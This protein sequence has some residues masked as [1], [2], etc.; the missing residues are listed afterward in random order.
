MHQLPPTILHALLSLEK[1]H[2]GKV[3]AEVWN[4][5]EITSLT[6]SQLVNQI[7]R[8]AAGYTRFEI[9]KG[10]RVVIFSPHHPCQYAAYLAAMAVQAIPT[11]LTPLTRKLQPDIYW[12]QQEH[13][14][15]DIKPDLIISDAAGATLLKE[16]LPEI[17]ARLAIFE[18]FENIPSIATLEDLINDIDTDALALIQYSSGT[19][20]PRKAVALSHRSLLAQIES[21]AQ[22]LSLREDDRIA[23][24]LPLYHDMGLITGFIL[25]V[26]KGISFIA[27]D[28]LEWT[29]QPTKLLDAIESFKATLCWLPN[30][31]FSHM[32][33][34]L[35]A[36]RGWSLE[37]IRMM[38]N[39]S[40]PCRGKTFDAFLEKFEKMGIRKD[41]LQASYA[42]AENVF[43]VTQT[44]LSNSD[45]RFGDIVSSGVPIDGVEIKITSED[46]RVLDGEEVGEILIRSSFCLHSYFGQSQSALDS[47]GWY[48]TNDLGAKV[49]NDLFVLGRKDDVIVSRG[50][51]I[52]ASEIESELASIEGIKAGRS[53]CLGAYS[54]LAGSNNLVV[55]VELTAQAN[56]KSI[57][58]QIH[59]IVEAKCGLAPW[60]VYFVEPGWIVKTSSGKI[61]RRTNGTK[62]MSLHNRAST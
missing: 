55:I 3:L 50:K 44:Q 37:S 25:P 19:T 58:R 43:A 33:R 31:A 10:A 59:A 5:D 15:A 35:P 14:L 2:P 62:V 30:F 40:E 26:V 23:T 51:N 24:W 21:Y 49:D 29:A 42:M 57:Q 61:D 38:I 7:I 52:F 22:A 54:E 41:A 20:G 12:T 48:H 32:A 60:A 13:L 56:A 1:T 18:E 39:C 53:V 36:E 28:P 47:D 6:L 11:F 16:H 46:G 4:K 17:R 34:N 27:M 45:R 9:E 8:F